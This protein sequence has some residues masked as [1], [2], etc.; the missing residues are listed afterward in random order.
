ML[1]LFVRNIPRDPFQHCARRE[2]EEERTFETCLI[3]SP[4]RRAE[5]ICGGQKHQE[6][7][8]GYVIGEGRVTL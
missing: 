1:D 2:G 3:L 7:S 8:G 5:N 6:G 4:L